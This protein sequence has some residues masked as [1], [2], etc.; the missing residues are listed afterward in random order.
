MPAVNRPP[1][2]LAALWRDLGLPSDYLVTRAL[3]LH[4]EADEATLVTIA[5]HDDGRPIRLTTPAAAAWHRL[6][7]AAAR[8]NLALL[9]LS[10][11]RS[12]ARQAALIR[13]K[14]AAGETLDSIL[15]VVAAPGCSEHH[16]G[17][18]LDLGA[19]EDTALDEDFARTT[20][21]RWLSTHAAAHGFGLSYPPGNPHGIAYEPWH[22]CW[23]PPPKELRPSRL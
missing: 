13:A 6:R 17:R 14:L 5:H 22:W 16:T 1:A 10:G 18:A 11:F 9:P 8:E 12:I 23:H 7:A 15:R 4:A 19:P 2:S 20:A 21:F 3:P